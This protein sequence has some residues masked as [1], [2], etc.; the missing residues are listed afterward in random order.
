MLP[1]NDVVKFLWHRVKK[2][3]PIAFACRLLSLGVIGLTLPDRAWRL[4]R[5]K[6]EA[7][8]KTNIHKQ[9]MGNWMILNLDDKGISHELLLD[10]E[11]EPF[12][13]NLIQDNVKERDVVVDIGANIGYY[14]LQE[15]R[16]VDKE[17][18][19]YAIEPVFSNATTLSA[20]RFLNDFGNIEITQCAISDHKGESWIY[21]GN[22][23]N[24]ASMNKNPAR[25]Y[26][27]GFKV[28]T[29]TLDTFLE[30][31]KLPDII[32]M[33]VEGYEYEVILG[34]NK[35]LDSRQPLMIFMEMHLNFLDREKIQEILCLLEDAGFEIKAIAQEPHPAI[36]H[37][38]WAYR[39]IN[40]LWKRMGAGI[41]Y[42]DWNIDDVLMNEDCLNGQIEYLEIMFE[43][44]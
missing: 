40:W 23:S 8:P 27:K 30:G 32:R 22:M 10:G 33:D 38:V 12:L 39:I 7:Y 44:K 1:V 24:T 26:S 16:L 3:K 9:I 11:R 34:M 37:V 4:Y 17:G 15:A 31:K 14:A 25:T 42:L 41:G 29:M 19:V 21:T 43:R 20:N 13:T 2:D 18:I 36:Q 28:E 6:K 35:L 5:I